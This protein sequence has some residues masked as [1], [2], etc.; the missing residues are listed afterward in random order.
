MNPKNAY[1]WTKFQMNRRFLDEDY[2]FSI[3]VANV[4]EFQVKRSRPN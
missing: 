2:V 4:G 1:C 3:I